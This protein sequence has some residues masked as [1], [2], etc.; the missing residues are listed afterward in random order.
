M[1]TTA[2]KTAIEY[3]KAIKAIDKSRSSA[4]NLFLTYVKE[5]LIPI[6]SNNI[7][8]GAVIEAAR[9]FFAEAFPK[10]VNQ[11]W[12]SE[13]KSST[14]QGLN[15]LSAVSGGSFTFR[16]GSKDK[17]SSSYRPFISW[18]EASQDAEAAAPEAAAPEAAAP[19]AAAPEAAAPEA[20]APEAAAPEAAAPEAAK[21]ITLDLIIPWLAE[22]SDTDLT[23]LRSAILTE[24]KRRADLTRAQQREIAK[25]AKAARE[26]A[27]QQQAIAA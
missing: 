27:Q 21:P 7:G 14:R 1:T 9:Q 6:A 5:E 18:A 4:N 16:Q 26:A 20:A 22:C 12:V 8:V 2:N 15:L 25:Q 3:G 24:L 17:L 23:D 11:A 10:G 19:E 13:V